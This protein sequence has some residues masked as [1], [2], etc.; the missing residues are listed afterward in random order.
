[1]VAPLKLIIYASLYH[2]R[3]SNSSTSMVVEFVGSFILIVSN[4]FGAFEFIAGMACVAFCLTFFCIHHFTVINELRSELLCHLP[5]QV[6]NACLTYRR[7]QNVS[8]MIIQYYYILNPEDVVIGRLFFV[9][10]YL[11]VTVVNFIDYSDIDKMM[12][13]NND[14]C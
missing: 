7:R 1:M 2:I 13:I 3:L 6:N 9:C 8:I 12:D 11:Y 5:V 4:F 14:K 10:F